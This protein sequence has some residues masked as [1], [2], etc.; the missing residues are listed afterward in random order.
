MGILTLIEILVIVL[1]VISNNNIKDRISNYH[2]YDNS[3]SVHGAMKENNATVVIV[4]A[5]IKGSPIFDQKHYLRDNY[6]I[7]DE[8]LLYVCYTQQKYVSE[9][10]SDGNATYRWR[11]KG[12]ATYYSPEIY[13]YDDIRISPLNC[14]TFEDVNHLYYYP[15]GDN[16]VDRVGDIRYSISYV[17]DMDTLTCLADVGNGVL[18][19][20][21][22]CNYYD[23]A[24]NEGIDALEKSAT[25]GGTAVI[26]IS[27]IVYISILIIMKP[28]ET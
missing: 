18:T 6:G 25:V 14:Y 19:I 23:I 15:D 2:V 12:T 20:Q 4:N 17:T 27:L 5:P 8:H 1:C 16:G 11:D 21:P 9:T 3:Q 10:D 26:I 28:W 22:M 13:I 24:F 7:S